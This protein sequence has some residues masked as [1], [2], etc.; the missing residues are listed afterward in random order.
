MIQMTHKIQP[1]QIFLK[2][3]DE[4]LGIKGGAKKNKKQKY[5]R[6]KNKKVKRKQTRRKK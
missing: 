4:D 3:L 5:S 2:P 6:R 1:L